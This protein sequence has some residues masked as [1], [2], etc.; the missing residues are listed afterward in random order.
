MATFYSRP[1]GTA[2]LKLA[3]TGLFLLGGVWRGVAGGPEKNFA[4]R[5]EAEFH[6]AQNGFQA[7]T[8][9]P[10]NVWRFARASFNYAELATNA[11]VRADVARAGIAACQQFLARAPKSAPGHYYLAL[12]SGELADALAPSMTSY[13]LVHEIEREFKVA[14]ELDEK[15]DFA[16]PARCLGLL[17][18]DAPGWPVSIGSKR[19]A[20]EWLDRAAA[21]APEYPENQLNL[22]ETYL[23]WHQRDDARKFLEKLDAVWPVAQ[24]NFT[25]TIL[26][27]DWQ[28]WAT[29]RETV[30]TE[31]NRISSPKSGR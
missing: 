29:R 16:G 18:R 1:T 27:K 3:V 13:K 6:Q 11:I 12:N 21:L 25:G 9:N 23:Q 17:Y 20:R 2:K 5:A 8:G 31:L 28:D 14:A 15:L 10:T 26:E 4:A 19:K 30:R 24:T 22:A 7:D